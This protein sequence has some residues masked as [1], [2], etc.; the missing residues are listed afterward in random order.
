[1][2]PDNPP[3]DTIPP[4]WNLPAAVAA[5][6]V[7]GLG[8]ILSGHVKRGVILLICIGGLWT[9]GLLIGGVSVVSTRSVNGTLR[10]WF[11]GQAMIAPSFVV[12]YTHDRL[13]AR[14]EGNDPSPYDETI[15]FSPAYGRAAEIGTLYCALAGM[16]NL[17]AIIDIAYR[18]PRSTEHALP[19]GA[20]E[21]TG[22]G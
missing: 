18:E 17:L 3:T 11:L 19:L 2:T 8:H 15:A 4:V 10:A 12:E 6:L 16:L 20:G 5:W 1:M 22:A 7:P 13:R 14:T 21:E 9:S